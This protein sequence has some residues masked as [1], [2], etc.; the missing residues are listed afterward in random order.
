MAQAFNWRNEEHCSLLNLAQNQLWRRSIPG[1]QFSCT[2]AS[3]SFWTKPNFGIC[4]QVIAVWQ[5]AGLRKR[6]CLDKSVIDSLWAWSR[7]KTMELCRKPSY[8]HTRHPLWESMP[9]LQ[10]HFDWQENSDDW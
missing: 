10:R 2:E 7:Q 5:A 6:A 8:E 9:E 4:V 1:V 3:Q